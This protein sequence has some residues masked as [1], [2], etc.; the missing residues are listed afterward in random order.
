MMLVFTPQKK[1]STTCY[2]VMPPHRQ[3]LIPV[4]LFFSFSQ[5]NK[6]LRGTTVTLIQNFRSLRRDSHSFSSSSVPSVQPLSN[7]RQACGVQLSSHQAPA[8]LAM[9]HIPFLLVALSVAGSTTAYSY[10]HNK[11]AKIS[12]F[13]PAKFLE[14][15]ITNDLDCRAGQ[16]S[17]DITLPVDHCLWGDYFLVNNFQITSYPTCGNGAKAATYFYETTS[18]TGNR[19]SAL[20]RLMSNSKVAVFLGRR[21]RSGP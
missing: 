10:A 8:S 16:P 2:A 9:V 17:T 1:V 5:G 3:L 20:T 4:F 18:C 6:F 15:W 19:I 7:L 14:I 12:L 13:E 21:Q 11:E